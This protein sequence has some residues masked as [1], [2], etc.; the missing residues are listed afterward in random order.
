MC[1]RK[2]LTYQL[3]FEALCRVCVMMDLQRVVRTDG[4]SAH[5]VP[6]LGGDLGALFFFVF[7][8]TFIHGNGM[9]QVRRGKWDFQ[10]LIFTDLSLIS[11]NSIFQVLTVHLFLFSGR[12]PCTLHA[13]DSLP[14]HVSRSGTA[15]EG[16]EKN[17]PA[18]RYPHSVL[19]LGRR[20]CLDS[21]GEIEE[22]GHFSEVVGCYAASFL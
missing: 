11:C 8:L 9:Q 5:S 20:K 2:A 7:R 19:W 6:L 12:K 22:Q 21:C 14:V 4:R 15:K 16:V 3:Y 17:A 1:M 10:P 13:Q 18:R